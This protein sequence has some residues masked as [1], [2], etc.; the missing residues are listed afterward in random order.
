VQR[1]EIVNGLEIRA[2]WNDSC[3]KWGWGH[4]TVRYFVFAVLSVL[5]VLAGNSYAAPQVMRATA[6]PEPGVL[7]ALGGGL[8]GLATLVRHKLNR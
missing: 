6:V 4:P 5:I 8:V 2:D 7:V 3:P 1:N